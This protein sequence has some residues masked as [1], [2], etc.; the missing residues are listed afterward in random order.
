M[1]ERGHLNG[2]RGL[3]PLPPETPSPYPPSPPPTDE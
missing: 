1:G 2:A 3:N